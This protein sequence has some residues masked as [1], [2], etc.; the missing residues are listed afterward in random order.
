M[1]EN[2]LPTED[3]TFT[4]LNDETGLIEVLSVKTGEVLAIQTSSDDLYQQ[5]SA[6]LVKYEVEGKEIYVEDSIDLDRV[7]GF[8]GKV[9]FSHTLIDL[10]CQA[11]I[12]GHSIK[13]ICS[14]D[15]FPSYYM[16]CKWKRKHE[17][18]ADALKQAREDRAEML[19]SEAVHLLENA[20]SDGEL[21]QAGALAEIK[22]WQAT[23]E[24]PTQYGNKVEVSG[25]QPLTFVL[26]TGIRRDSDENF[27]QDETKKLQEESGDAKS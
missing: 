19:V 8:R 20:K 22:K 4:C 24:A 17:W 11:I 2:L 3:E 14:R 9:R 10:I 7:K 18:V 6:Q 1:S 15:E 21:K 13:D 27:K 26:E 25:Q 23:K 12:E 16:L 5:K